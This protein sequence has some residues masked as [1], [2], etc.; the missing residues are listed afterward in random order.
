MRAPASWARFAVRAL[1]G[2]IGV[3]AVAGLWEGYKAVGPDAGVVVHGV[4]ILPRTTDM[5]MPHVW[6]MLDKF[7]E[8]VNIFAGDETVGSAV[9]TACLFSLRLAATG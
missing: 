2:T 9:T 4:V 3:L 8:P 7:S 1:L 6:D 5:A